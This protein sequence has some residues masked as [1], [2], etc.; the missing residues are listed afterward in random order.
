MAGWDAGAY[1]RLS[2]LGKKKLSMIAGFN[3]E[4]FAG[5]KNI[6]AKV[7]GL[8]SAFI[9]VLC[10]VL[11]FGLEFVGGFTGILFAVIVVASTVMVMIYSNK[12]DVK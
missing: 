11:P 4:E 1:I 12:L 10:I 2:Y 6:L 5:D 8:F 7:Y 3:E 9:G